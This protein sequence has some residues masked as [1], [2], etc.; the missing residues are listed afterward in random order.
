MLLFCLFTT[1]NVILTMKMTS[2]ATHHQTFLLVPVIESNQLEDN[3]SLA[4][5]S[6]GRYITTA[7][8][9]IILNN[10]IF[11][12]MVNIICHLISLNF[13][14]VL[15]ISIYCSIIIIVHS[16]YITTSTLI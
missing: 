12:I 4:A 14:I 13:I 2:E 16:Q 15:I 7:A 10:Q 6:I 5:S 8:I 3:L 1:I 9:L 11:T